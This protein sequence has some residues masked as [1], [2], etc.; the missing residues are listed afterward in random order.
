MKLR[1]SEIIEVKM[2]H[3]QRYY[4]SAVPFMQRQINE[5]ELNNNTEKKSERH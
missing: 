2:A 4:N 3:T 1:K 5:Y